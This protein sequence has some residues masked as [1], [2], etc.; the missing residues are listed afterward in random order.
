MNKWISVKDIKFSP[1]YNKPVIVTDGKIVDIASFRFIDGHLKAWDKNKLKS[2]VTHW[3]M[4]PNLPQI[5]L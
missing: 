5:H 3:M 4:L 2:G 1:P